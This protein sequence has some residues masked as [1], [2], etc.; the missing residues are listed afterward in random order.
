MKR[1]RNLLKEMQIPP[2][3]TMKKK[4]LMKTRTKLSLMK[5]AGKVKANLLMRLLRSQ[6]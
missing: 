1:K 3:M 5:K 4:K 6:R 2:K